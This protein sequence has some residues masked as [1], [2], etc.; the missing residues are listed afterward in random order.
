M[1]T[2]PYV[3]QQQ[4][5]IP[6]QMKMQREESSITYYPG[7]PMNHQQIN[8]MNHQQIRQDI[9]G[10]TDII[11]TDVFGNR[12]EIKKDIYGNTDVIKNDVFGDRIEIQTDKFG[13]RNE[14]RQDKFGNTDVI[15]TDVFG[16]QHEIINS[17][18]NTFSNSPTPFSNPNAYETF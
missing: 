10:N 13:N 11:Q 5:F 1:K 18:P 12:Q 17:N 9:F 7:P 15:Q 2:N 14:I 3:Q 8:P 6:P 16:N 4:S